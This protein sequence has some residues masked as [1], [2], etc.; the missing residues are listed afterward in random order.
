[1]NEQLI[2]FSLSR[3]EL[4][5]I[6]KD[7]IR[8]EMDHKKEKELLTF[9]E[10]CKLLNVSASCLNQWKASNKIPF[11]KMGKRIYFNKQELMESLKDSSYFQLKGLKC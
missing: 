10:T 9:K 1:M 2:F 3:D 8:E 11:K 6:I 4:K 5:E 7:S